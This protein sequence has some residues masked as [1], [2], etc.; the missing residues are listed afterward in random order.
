M[1]AR[2]IL[3]GCLSVGLVGCG[4][5]GGGHTQVMN[6]SPSVPSSKGELRTSEDDNGNIRLALQVEHLAPPAKVAPDAT[7]Y[8][9]WIQPGSEF[10]QNVGALKIGDDLTAK[11]ETLTP[12]RSFALTVTPEPSS[13]VSKPTHEAVFRSTVDLGN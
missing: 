13:R 11:L 3:G 9:T 7:V 12:Y 10:I 1:N 8:V 5:F 2:S 4:L 6:A